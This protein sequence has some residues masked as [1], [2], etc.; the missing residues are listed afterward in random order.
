[1][2]AR[3]QQ[4]ADGSRVPSSTVKC[5]PADVVRT[6]QANA[7]PVVWTG[8]QFHNRRQPGQDHDQDRRGGAISPMLVASVAVGAM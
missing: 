6:S 2:A 8:M 1:M 5:C 3:I 4:V 7:F